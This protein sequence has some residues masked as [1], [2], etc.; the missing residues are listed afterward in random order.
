MISFWLERLRHHVAVMDTLGSRVCSWGVRSV[1]FLDATLKRNLC[2][3]VM[4]SGM[5]RL[6]TG[7]SP[8]EILSHQPAIAT[9]VPCK[10]AFYLMW[11]TAHPGQLGACPLPTAPCPR[12]PQSAWHLS[13]LP[14]LQSWGQARLHHLLP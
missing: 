5:G 6:M 1:T 8:P 13:L 11:G 4:F 14:I 7:L 3:K 9:P 2:S 10:L 12:C